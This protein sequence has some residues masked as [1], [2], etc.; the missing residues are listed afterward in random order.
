MRFALC[1]ALLV[2][3]ACG[4]GSAPR[5]PAEKA[6]TPTP[7]PDLHGVI[8]GVGENPTWRLDADPTANAM[9]LSIENGRET[10]SGHYTEPH[11]SA[12]GGFEMDGGDVMLD[13]TVQPCTVMGTTYPLH[14]IAQ[15]HRQAAVEG[16]AFVRWDKNLLQ[17]MPQIDACLAAS[18]GTRRVN[19]AGAYE[20]GTLVR[21]VS[22]S[23]NVD[24]RVA[25]GAA[26]VT[27]RNE[28]VRVPGDGDAIFV[29]APGEQPG[30]ECFT[31][32]EVKAA[33]GTLLGWMDDPQ[34]C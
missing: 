33:D 6:A 18:P 16:C 26:T 24:C 34:G 21:M 27:P 7:D 10:Y 28:N 23:A 32:P 2:L 20:N 22:D 31:A 30:G 13:L 19:Y 5:A 8:I 12:E 1:A 3:A 15:P 9:V 29:R 17:L 14:A 4:Q 25:S 11:R